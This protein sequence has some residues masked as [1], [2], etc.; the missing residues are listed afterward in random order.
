MNTIAGAGADR[1]FWAGWGSLGEVGRSVGR[2]Q[3]PSTHLVPSLRKG[4]GTG[5]RT[6]QGTA[7]F[8]QAGFSRGHTRAV[9]SAPGER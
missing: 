1:G 2:P 5:L 8:S 3:G 7:E 4:S 9:T 6:D